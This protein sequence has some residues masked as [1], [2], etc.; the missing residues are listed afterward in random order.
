MRKTIYLIILF[1]IQA[2][3]THAGDGINRLL[4]IS[5][6]VDYHLNNGDI[7]HQTTMHNPMSAGNTVGG[8]I[9]AEL[10]WQLPGRLFFATGIDLKTI[11]QKI[12]IHYNAADAGFNGSTVV[13]NEE[14][15][16]TNYYAAPFARGGYAFPVRGNNLDVSLGIASIISL[17][18][19]VQDKITALNITDP[20]YTDLVI[21]THQTWGNQSEVNFL[22]VNMLI[23]LQMAYRFS[24]GKRQ[25]RVGLDF[26]S[27]SSR[28]IN[29]TEV[30]YFGPRR[31]QSGYSVF[32]DKFQSVSLIA[33][34]SL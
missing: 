6:G 4:F 20:I 3:T 8:H 26:S 31:V 16:Y 29:R 21:Y 10:F 25:L 1:I 11:R 34:I 9:G 19:R 17:S 24:L 27:G 32:A 23:V 5:S 30:Y 12:E 33:G 13:Y 7:T 2:I 14:I 28:Q 18:G 22:P 15:G